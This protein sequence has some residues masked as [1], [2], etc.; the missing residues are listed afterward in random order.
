MRGWV[1]NAEPD[2]QCSK[3]TS[4]LKNS[5]SSKYGFIYNAN[6]NRAEFR[7]VERVAWDQKAVRAKLTTLATPRLDQFVSWTP[8]KQLS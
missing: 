4:C 2:R 1:S 8:P 6:S 7:Q 5:Q 3:E